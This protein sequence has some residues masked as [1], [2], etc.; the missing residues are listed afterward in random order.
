MRDIWFSWLELHYLITLSCCHDGQ[1]HLMQS[2]SEH[3]LNRLLLCKFFT[4]PSIWLFVTVGLQS[5]AWVFYPIYVFIMPKHIDSLPRFLVANCISFLGAAV[6]HYSELNSLKGQRFIFSQRGQE[7]KINFTAL[8]RGAARAGLSP[9]SLP[10]F[11][12]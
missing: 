1:L 10:L 5:F 8:K 2:T 11:G 4:W 12:F 9:S 7:S 6:T 3:W